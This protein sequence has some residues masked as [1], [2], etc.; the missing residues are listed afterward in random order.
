MAMP[1][2]RCGMNGRPQPRTSTAQPI[3]TG[4]GDRSRAV[5]YGI[6]TLFHYARHGGWEDGTKKLYEEW[7]RKQ[8]KTKSHRIKQ[9][10][11]RPLCSARLR[12]RWSIAGRVSLF[13]DRGY[14]GREDCNYA[15]FG[16]KY[17]LGIKFAGR[18]TKKSRVLYLAA[19]NPIDVQMR[20]MA[21]AQQMDFV[22]HEIEVFFVE[23]GIHSLKW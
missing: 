11:C 18:E 9:R 2:D 19:E 4:Y 15:A 12:C 8:P 22:A 14:G 7:C 23:G 3:R 17:R 13:A 1:A 5:A 6:G 10:V 16:R 20:W 21:L